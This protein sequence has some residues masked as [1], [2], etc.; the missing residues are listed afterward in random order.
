M[1]IDVLRLVRTVWN[2]KLARW[3]H[4]VELS[5][6]SHRDLLGFLRRVLR[7][8]RREYGGTFRMSVAAWL[9][10]HQ[11]DFGRKAHWMGVKAE[12]NPLDSWIY[13]EIAYEVRPDAI[14]EIGSCAG[15]STLMLAHFLD[16]VGKGKVISIDIDRERFVAEHERIIALTG[17]S[18]SPE[19]ISKVE[20]L[21]AGGSVLVIHDGDHGRDQVLAD[22]EVYSRLVTVGSYLIVED[23]I[24]DLFRP[25]SG[26]GIFGLWPR[27]GPLP[28]IDRFLRDNPDFVIDQSRERYLITYNPHGYLKR[29]R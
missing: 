6:L 26:A 16:L 7:P 11:R 20:E 27:G 21:C 19:I 2:K 25:M 8:E 17:N 18:R 9:K 15:G 12:K 10:A 23:G 3:P 14:I 28:A 29:I 4:L 1:R 24:V 5:Q 13:Q 22:L